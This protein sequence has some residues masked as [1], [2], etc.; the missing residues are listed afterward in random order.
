MDGLEEKKRYL[1]V[2][3]RALC[4]ESGIRLDF[5]EEGHW[6]INHITREIYCPVKELLAHGA[7]F[8]AGCIAHEIGHDYLSRQFALASAC[9]ERVYLHRLLNCL[10]D[11]RV[12]AWM[13][14]K[15]PGVGRWISYFSNVSRGLEPSPTWRRFPLLKRFFAGCCTLRE[16]GDRYLEGDAVVDALESTWPARQRY[17][18]LVPALNVYQSSITAAQEDLYRSRALPRLR[19]DVAEARNDGEKQVFLYSLAGLELVE[20]ELSGPVQDLIDRDIERLALG[21]AHENVIEVAEGMLR[22]GNLQNVEPLV[23]QIFARSEGRDFARPA[24]VPFKLAEELYLAY[25]GEAKRKAERPVSRSVQRSGPQYHPYVDYRQKVQ[26]QVVRFRQKVLEALQQ[27]R[28]MAEQQ[29]Y[30]WGHRPDLRKMMAFEADPRNYRKL[31]HRRRVPERPSVAFLLLVDLSGSMRGDK[32]LAAVEGTVLLVETLDRLMLPFAVYGFQDV[33]IPFVGFGEPLDEETQ[34]RIA[35]MSLEVSSQRPGGNNNH[36]TNDDGP[37]LLTATELL[38]ERPERDKVLIVIS[39]GA[40]SG[41]GA[42][43]AALHAAVKSV[44]AKGVF[45]Y[46]LGLGPNTEHVDK[47]YPNALANILVEKLAGELGNLLQKTL[48]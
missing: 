30:P 43:D 32:I 36:G 17:H 5:V 3:T 7:E 42:T 6:S 23:H 35:E 47:Y 46:G 39:D 19:D 41:G 18:A 24:T 44:T 4:E 40:P 28:R 33:I 15:F 48:V 11:P 14:R 1:Q 8:C 34:K 22:T 29:G 25:W 26:A 21:L 31:W 38:L 37:C 10:E 16:S 12:E 9:L 13:A 2:L 20:Q 45:L 27:K